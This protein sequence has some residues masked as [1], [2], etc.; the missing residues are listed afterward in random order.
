MKQKF[1]S[2]GLALVMLLGVAGCNITTPATVGT[3]GGVEIPA[4]IYLLAQYTA[5][6]TT[7]GL[8]DFATGYR[9]LS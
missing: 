7:A 4:G 5:Y 1:I 6:N 2:L 9:K 8:V 3:I